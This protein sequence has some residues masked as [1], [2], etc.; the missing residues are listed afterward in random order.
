MLRRLSVGLLAS[1][2]ANALLP[3]KAQEGSA[4]DLGDVMNIS[5]KDVVKPSVSFHGGC[6]CAGKPN[7]DGIGTSIH[8]CSCLEQLE[9]LQIPTIR[10]L[11]SSTKPSQ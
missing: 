10:P 1:A 4:E 7:Q 3:L 2:V 6:Q 9:R 5:L 11:L 8:P